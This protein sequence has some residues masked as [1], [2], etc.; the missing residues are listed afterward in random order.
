MILYDL[1]ETQAIN[2]L[3]HVKMNGKIVIPTVQ[4]MTP[5]YFSKVSSGIQSPKFLIDTQKNIHKSI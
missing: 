2:T 5:T 1:T 4:L 3:R